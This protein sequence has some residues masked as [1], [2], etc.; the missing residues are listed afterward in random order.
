[1]NEETIRTAIQTGHTFGSYPDSY[2]LENQVRFAYNDALKL[3]GQ[4][5]QDPATEERCVKIIAKTLFED[6]P[7]L[8]DNELP[9]LMQAGV[10]GELGK[11]TWV[12]GAIVL[13]WVRLYSRHQMRLNIVDERHEDKQQHRLTNEEKEQRNQQAHEDG[14]NKGLE[15]YRKNGTIFH[16]E[17]FAMGQWPAML[18]DEYRRRGVIPDPTDV[19]R[20]Y[21]EQGARVHD[22][23]HPLRFQLTAESMRLH[24][25]DLIKAYLLEAYYKQITNL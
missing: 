11:E 22:Q 14:Y 1:M 21:A 24:R 20:E 15:C 10:S 4:G 13:Q 8:T 12:S 19:Q 16:K 3:R 25:N 18:Y 23:Q 17:G 9:I 5:T 7:N 6:Y 2:S